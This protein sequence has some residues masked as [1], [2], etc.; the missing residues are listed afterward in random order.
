MCSNIRDIFEDRDAAEDKEGH[1]QEKRHLVANSSDQDWSGMFTGQTGRLSF[2][3]EALISFV[4][5]SSDGQK[6]PAEV[7]D[8]GRPVQHPADEEE[9]KGEE[10]SRPQE[11][12]A[13]AGDR[14]EIALWSRILLS[15][16][17][18]RT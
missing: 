12:T 3:I 13:R 4:S 7:G 5:V 18:D 15:T 14:G 6:R 9:E 16:N 8:G 17:M 1:H 2:P 10:G 11:A